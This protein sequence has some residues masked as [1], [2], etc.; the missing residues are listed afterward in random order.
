MLLEEI[1]IFSATSAALDQSC[2]VKSLPYVQ[3]HR[4]PAM[5]MLCMLSQ[6]CVTSLTNLVWLSLTFAIALTLTLLSLRE[7]E[8]GVPALP[9]PVITRLA[10]L[11]SLHTNHTSQSGVN[12]L[13][14][15][16]GYD[17][18]KNQWASFR[19]WDT[20]LQHSIF[21][22]HRNGTGITPENLSPHSP[23]LPL[24]SDCWGNL[25][26][27][28]PACRGACLGGFLPAVSPTPTRKSGAGWSPARAPRHQRVPS[29]SAPLPPWERSTAGCFQ[30]RQQPACATGR[31]LCRE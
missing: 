30:T 16:S 20:R 23:S 28:A 18:L 21:L 6:S 10:K 14:P 25:L 29:G 8:S 1:L 5:S 4:L 31:S 13:A 12:H 9:S 24:R 11:H 15:P 27:V 17:H 2:C 22:I 3:A 19:G 7:T 26:V